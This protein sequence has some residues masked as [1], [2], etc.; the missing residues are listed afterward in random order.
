M[1]SEGQQ[2]KRSRGREGDRSFVTL[3]RVIKRFCPDF[4]P[5]RRILQE[6]GAQLASHTEQTD[7]FFFVPGPAAQQEARRLK[8]RLEDGNPNCIYYYDRD[9]LVQSSGPGKVSFQRFDVS[10]P[11][12][13]DV[14]ETA[15]GI[16][17]TVRK[18]REIWH[19]GNA[20]FNL[21]QVEGIGQVFELE[22][23]PERNE[24]G[25][26]LPYEYLEF[27]SPYLGEEIAGSNEDL[28]PEHQRKGLGT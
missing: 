18:Q 22:I 3:D 2:D 17:K 23:S 13:Q 27:F 5:I 26:P 11:V 10:D 4:A 25:E 9:N 28:V 7:L 1:D 20:V 8:L 6:L 16:Q 19:H 15:L 24:Q 21:D 12:I 14:L